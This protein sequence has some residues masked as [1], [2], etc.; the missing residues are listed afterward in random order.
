[1][2]MTCEEAGMTERWMGMTEGES[3][4]TE[5]LGCIRLL[6]SPSPQPSPLKGRGSINVEGLVYFFGP[7]A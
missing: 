4:R 6:P 7:H 2:G 5:W 1:M 3:G